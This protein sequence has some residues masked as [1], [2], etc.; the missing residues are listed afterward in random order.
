MRGIVRRV[1]TDVHV[2][3]SLMHVYVHIIMAPI[4]ILCTYNS[5]RVSIT[6]TCMQPPYRTTH[7]SVTATFSKVTWSE[8]WIFLYGGCCIHVTVMLTLI[9]SKHKNKVYTHANTRMGFTENVYAGHYISPSCKR[10][11][12]HTS[13][14][15]LHQ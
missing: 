10:I 3:Q 11:C 6:V 5:I 7:Q 14:H 4:A 1:H 2:I 9:L 13:T 15:I 8:W 12:S